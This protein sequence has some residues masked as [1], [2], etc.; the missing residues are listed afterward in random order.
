[1]K[2]ITVLLIVLVMM[3]HMTMDLCAQENPDT[4]RSGSITF[5]MNY[6][7][8]PME[9]GSLTIYRVGA[10]IKKIDAFEFMLIEPLGESGLT[11]DELDDSMLAEKLMNLV[12]EKKLDGISSSIKKGKVVF[13]DLKPGLYLVTQRAEETTEGFYPVNPFLISLPTWENGQYIYDLTGEPKNL[14]HHKPVEPGKTDEPDESDDSNESE[15]L[16]E[17]DE[18]T[19]VLPQTGQ[20]NWPIPL[21]AISGA[22][23]F[24]FGYHVYFGKRDEFEK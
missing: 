11:L 16:R 19:E 20:L 24:V 2:K 12:S 17:P 23:L 9:G 18:L 22:L 13:R 6:N 8:K 7:Q 5:S 14:P 21:M 4:N 3:F 15:E 10:I 1:M